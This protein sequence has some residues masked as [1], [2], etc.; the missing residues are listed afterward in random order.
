MVPATC[1]LRLF[2]WGGAGWGG[3]G[4]SAG[5]DG[6]VFIWPAGA[7][8]QQAAGPSVR[9]TPRQVSK[10]GLQPVQFNAV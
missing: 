6:G 1:D 2:L 9:P 7:R 5:L 10:C 3:V 8:A 4:Q